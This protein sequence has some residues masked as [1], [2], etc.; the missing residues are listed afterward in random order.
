MDI[1]K[2]GLATAIFGA[3]ASTTE[4]VAFFALPFAVEEVAKAGARA[5]QES[6]HLS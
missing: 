3:G 2:Q 4:K 6:A 5:G 1:I